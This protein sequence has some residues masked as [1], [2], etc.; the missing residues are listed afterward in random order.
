MRVNVM[1]IDFHTAKT[2]EIW[3][4]SASRSDL[5]QNER[6]VIPPVFI[7]MNTADLLNPKPLLTIISRFSASFA[8]FVAGD[9]YL[10]CCWRKFRNR[11]CEGQSCRLQTS[12]DRKDH[13][14][15]TRCLA[16]L[17]LVAAAL[18]TPLSLA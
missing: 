3:P 2:S 17:P 16:L 8:S 4:D 5:L 13:H 6:F 11:C 12:P 15:K 10:V 14:M 18:L 1:D 9:C 7:R